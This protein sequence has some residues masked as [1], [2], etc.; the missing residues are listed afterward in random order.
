MLTRQQTRTRKRARLQAIADQV[1]VELWIQVLS[2]LPCRDIATTATVCK[3][4]AAVQ[5][6]VLHQACS[7]RFPE[8]TQA[9]R[10]P[11]DANWKRLYDVFEQRERD[12]TAVASQAAVAQTQKV[13]LPSHRAVL[14][15]W[16]IE[17]RLSADSGQ[18]VLA[19]LAESAADQQ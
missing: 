10:A 17:V 11:T 16:L 12:Y 15:E 2:H 13:V 8:W 14:A 19:L 9:S 18:T 6:E 3:S 7:R 4:F 1:P 5:Q